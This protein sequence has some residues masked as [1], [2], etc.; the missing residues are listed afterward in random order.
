MQD[1]LNN[2]V[3]WFGFGLVLFLLE[4]A[5]PGFILFFFGI[6][7]WIVALLSLFTDISINTQ[8]AIFLVSSVGSAA[9]FRNYIKTKF[10]IDKKAP[11]M[12]EDEFVGKI[13][14]AETAI[15]SGV[16]G[17]VEFKG[18]SWDA[19]SN[20]LIAPG[21]SVIITATH[22]ILLIVKSTKNI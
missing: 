2:A 8:L 13:A 3:L 20:D 21:E 15:A 5:L 10:G 4:F 1:F 12:L 7:A 19:S 22:S 14:L 6:G 11:Q 17:K 18:T 16:N 9:L